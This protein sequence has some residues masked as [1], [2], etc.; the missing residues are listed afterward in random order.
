MS[1]YYIVTGAAGMIG[2]NIVAGLNARGIKNIIAVDNLTKGDK[3]RNLVDCEIADYLDKHEFRE[4]LNAGAFNGS[5]EAILHQGACSNTME[6]NGQYMMD[7][8]FR[9]TVDVLEFCITQRVP[10]LYAS[11]AATYGASSTF[12]EEPEFERPLNVYGYSKILFDRVLRKRW[13]ELTAQ[14][15]GFRYFNVYGPRE[16]HKAGAGSSVAF[17][18]FHQFRKDGRVKLFVGCDGYADGGQLRDFIYVE[19]V[20]NANLFFLEH[21]EKSGIYNL[22]TGRAQSFNDVAHA[23]VNG[24]REYEGKSVLTLVEMAAQG[25]IEYVAFPDIL[26]GKYQSYTQADI[27]RLRAA[28][29]TAAFHDVGN[30]VGKYCKYLLA[31]A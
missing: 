3:F 4:L 25:L 15:V 29:Y 5:V 16:A 17:N 7:N 27:S 20:V 9:Y 1:R 24:I 8:N 22:G 21:P 11:S 2:S 26:K 13:S 30:G 19:D 18:A 10:L 23:I 31:G 6:H 28:G 14:A 12:R